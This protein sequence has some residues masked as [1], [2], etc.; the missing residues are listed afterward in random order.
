MS[1]VANLMDAANGTSGAEA[2]KGRDENV[3]R[4][5]GEAAALLGTP[6]QPAQQ[7]EE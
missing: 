1:S 4:L 7:E 5:R 3:I 2:R 6:A